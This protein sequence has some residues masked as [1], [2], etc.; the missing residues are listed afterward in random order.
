MELV[1]HCWKKLIRTQNESFFKL[2][3]EEK[4][5]LWQ[6]PNHQEGFGQLFVVSDEQKLD[7][8]DMFFITTRPHNVRRVDL[9]DK[10]PPKFGS[11]STFL[12]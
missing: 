12:V 9:F 5:K 7:W 11:L 10:L 3:Y 8:A 6:Q 4:K 1:L 2:P